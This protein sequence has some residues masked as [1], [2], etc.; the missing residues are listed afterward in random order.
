M[1]DIGHLLPDPNEMIT[2]KIKSVTSLLITKNIIAIRT[3]VGVPFITR[4]ILMSSLKSY[5]DE[6]KRCFVRIFL[7]EVI[8]IVVNIFGDFDCANEKIIID[9]LFALFLTD[10]AHY[11]ENDPCN[12]SFIKL[13]D[14]GA[15]ITD[16]YIYPRIVMLPAFVFWYYISKY[17]LLITFRLMTTIVSEDRNYEIQDHIFNLWCSQDLVKD[18]ESLVYIIIWAMD[19]RQ[20][21]YVT[22]VLQIIYYHDEYDKIIMRAM[23]HMHDM[24]HLRDFMRHIMEHT[25]LDE[26][27][28][29]YLVIVRCH[30]LLVNPVGEFKQDIATLDTLVKSNQEADN[31]CNE[32]FAHFHR[33]N[34]KFYEK[35]YYDIIENLKKLNNLYICKLK[36][37]VNKYGTYTFIDK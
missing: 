31:I 5:L 13:I 23:I 4:E 19:H 20:R 33:D 22:N 15:M 28:L 35:G 2:D 37:L 1:N 11:D 16:E 36:F 17:D 12:N 6:G 18:W 9:K 29:L 26:I 8:N 7:N 10:D 25:Y 32:L 30:I 3:L 34:S 14:L 24:T 27:S 21:K